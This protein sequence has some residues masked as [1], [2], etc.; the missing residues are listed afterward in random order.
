M[1]RKLAIPE[2]LKLMDEFDAEFENGDDRHDNAYQAVGYA[3]FLLV[4][5]EE[6]GAQE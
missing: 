2:L 3:Y 5:L 4:G 1:N 6:S